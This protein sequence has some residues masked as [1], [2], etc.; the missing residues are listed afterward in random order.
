V[1]DPSEP[2]EAAADHGRGRQGG[3][4]TLRAVVLLVVFVVVAI[5]ALGKVHGPTNAASV[6]PPSTVASGSTTTTVAHAGS[7]TTTSTTHP[8][9]SVPVLVANATSVSGA[10]AGVSNQLQAVGWSMLP[11][12]NAS[13]RVTSSH[14]YYV[15]GREQEAASVASTLHLPSTSVAPYTTAAPISSIGTAEV[16]VVVGPDLARSGST[17]TTT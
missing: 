10:A 8:P 14:V 11:P 4:P 7:T 15:A 2:E 13:A 1:D 6:A 12:V 3:F 16:V 9:G 17:T 5:I